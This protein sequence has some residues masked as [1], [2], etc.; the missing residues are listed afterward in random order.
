MAK[1]YP[2]IGECGDQSSPEKLAENT[3]KCE[4]P[5]ALVCG[6]LAYR[7]TVTALESAIKRS[8]ARL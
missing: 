6:L 2:E 3:I 1:D 5:P 8:F 4:Q 7:V